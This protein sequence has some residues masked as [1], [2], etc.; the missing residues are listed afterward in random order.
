MSWGKVGEFLKQNGGKGLALVGS[1]VTGN[2]PGALALGASMVAQA[3]GTDDPEV[4]LQELQA[5]PETL[6]RLR[7]LALEKDKEIN[8]HI[9][10][11]MRLE[12][13]DEQKAHEI[14]QSTIQAGDKADDK[15]VR[16]TRPG[17]SWISLFAALVYAFTSSEPDVYV[18]GLLLTLPF[19]YAGLRQAGKWKD[20]DV[21]TK[22]TTR[23]NA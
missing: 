20:A 10:E 19:T 18:L 16:Y 22:L 1:L 17:Q 3:T 8:R 4:A 11:K 23:G 14:T 5:N 7:E 15:F 6:V 12:F 9:E 13:E 2:V 21:L